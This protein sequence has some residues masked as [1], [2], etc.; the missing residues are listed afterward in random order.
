M[1]E[2]EM[3][4]VSEEFAKCWKAAG[5]H[6]QNQAQGGLRSWLKADLNP[7]FLEHLSFRLG[8]QLF[9]VRIIDV[10]KQLNT[11]GNPE[12]LKMIADACKGHACFMPMQKINDHWVAVENGWGLVNTEYIS[13][14]PIELITED[15]VV[16]TDW[17]LQ[18]FA[19]QI[20]RDSLVEQGKELTSWHGNPAVHPSIWFVG[21]NGLEWV[22][23]K[24]IRWPETDC[25]IPENINEIADGVKGVAQKGH[26]A[27]V[28]VANANDP[29][30]P[31]AKA[32]GNF[33]QLYRG[34]KLSASYKGLID[35][36]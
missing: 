24:A 36:S 15:K 10:D 30:D 29:F 21:E 18:D 12:G 17:E 32:N 20:V 6:I 28:K 5:I 14:N 7:P 22:L 19:V 25:E 34:E 35:I 4:E 33:I 9:F 2:I 1:H 3:S 23:V 27:A 31:M 16:M 26:F 11:P 13:I 8:N